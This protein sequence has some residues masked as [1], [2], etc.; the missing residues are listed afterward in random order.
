MP[1][2]ILILLN[3]RNQ[4]TY[5][6]C[7]TLSEEESEERLDEVDNNEDGFVTWEEYIHETYGID[8]PE[9]I[10]LL[11]KSEQEDERM[12]SLL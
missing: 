3:I 9:D 8:N 5:K 12:V 11:E 7:R 4:Y 6:I 1:I 10:K 2:L